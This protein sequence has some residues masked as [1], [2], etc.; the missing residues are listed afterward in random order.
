MGI[1][2]EGLALK[3]GDTDSI[4]LGDMLEVDETIKT[5]PGE[6][7]AHPNRY[8]LVKDGST[9]F[10]FSIDP[11]SADFEKTLINTTHRVLDYTMAKEQWEE[12]NGKIPEGEFSIP[13]TTDFAPH[14]T[15]Y[16]DA[17]TDFTVRNISSDILEVKRAEIRKTEVSVALYMLTSPNVKFEIEKIENFKFTLPPFVIIENYTEDWI[18]KDNVL[19]HPGALYINDGDPICKVTIREIDMTKISEDGRGVMPDE[20]GEIRFE[21]DDAKADMEGDV[22][23]RT[24]E[25]FTMNDGDYADVQLEI[26]LGTGEKKV[27]IEKAE[28]RFNPTIDPAI[29][30][31][32]ISGDLPDF[33]KDPEV[34]IEA[35]N[36]TLRF[37]ADMTDIPVALEFGAQLSSVKE[38]VSGFRHDVTLTPVS[39]DPHE[40]KTIYYYDGSAPYDPEGEATNAE[41]RKIDGLNKLIRQLPDFIDVDLKDRTAVKHGADDYFTIT[42][43]PDNPKRF[44]GN[45]NYSIFVPFAFNKGLTIVYNDSTNSLKED[46]QDYAASGLAVSGVVESSIPL[47]LFASIQAIDEY[48]NPIPGINFSTAKIAAGTF[49]PLPQ[50]AQTNAQKEGYRATRTPITLEGT[51]DNPDLLRKIDRLAFRIEAEAKDGSRTHDLLSTQYLKF[52]DLRIKLKGQVIANFN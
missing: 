40:A 35:A 37:D 18:L 16:G 6:G 42:L 38:G 19:S 31:I 5:E 3:L 29:D 13:V 1:G 17:I 41:T 30:P 12:E 34:V 11:V 23:F 9:D 46:L 39:I 33:L 28:G 49:G 2:S 36:P 47:E 21:G 22:Y 26:K 15:A 4:K 24:T 44:A 27:Y 25:D 10:D 7:T 43:D 20:N 50:N 8:Y 48:N 32:D 51:L 52:L 45:A 14:G